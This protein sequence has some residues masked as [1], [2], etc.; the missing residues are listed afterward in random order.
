MFNMFVVALVPFKSHCYFKKM[1][2]PCKKIG[3]VSP[4]AG[5]RTYLTCFSKPWYRV[6]YTVY[7]SHCRDSGSLCKFITY[8]HTYIHT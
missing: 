1:Y 7:H 8:I 6:L 5:K 4:S 2:L 3:Q